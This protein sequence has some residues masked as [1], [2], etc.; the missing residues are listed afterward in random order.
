VELNCSCKDIDIGGD[1]FLAR[2][3]LDKDPAVENRPV[4]APLRNGEE[5]LA[6]WSD[7]RWYYRGT[8]TTYVLPANVFKIY[9]FF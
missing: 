2:A 3:P 4:P 5:V 9:F 1:S 8:R 6:Q 7:D